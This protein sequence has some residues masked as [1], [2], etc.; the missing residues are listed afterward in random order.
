MLNNLT[1]LNVYR[2]EIGNNELK[3]I[4][5][6]NQVRKFNMIFF[7]RHVTKIFLNIII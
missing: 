7:K 5:S 6:S 4:I 2:T 3:L 1:Q